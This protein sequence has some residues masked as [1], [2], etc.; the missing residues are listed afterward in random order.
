MALNIMLQQLVY[1]P[2]ELVYL[3][4]ELVYL[5]WELVYLQWESNDLMHM[6]QQL[7]IIIYFADFIN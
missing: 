3:P 5:P 1:L 2:W 6:N 7:C 4:W